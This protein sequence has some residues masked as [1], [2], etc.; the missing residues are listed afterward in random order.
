V[1]PASA[2]LRHHRS[3]MIRRLVDL[4]LVLEEAE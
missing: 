3:L 4:P 1:D 2:P